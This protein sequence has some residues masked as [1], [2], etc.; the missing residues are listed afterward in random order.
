MLKEQKILEKIYYDVDEGFGSARDLYEK[1]EE[2]RRG[3]KPSHG[4][5]MDEGTAEQADK[6]LQELQFLHCTVS[7]V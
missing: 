2:S 7:E 1:G 3:H 4:F 5:Q 6:K